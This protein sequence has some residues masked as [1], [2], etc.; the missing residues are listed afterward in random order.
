M[1]QQ[2]VKNFLDTKY[3]NTLC[4]LCD[5]R[6]IQLIKWYE[7]A[8]GDRVHVKCSSCIY[9]VHEQVEG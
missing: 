2:N 5:Q 8:H 3:P 1:E 6:S 9:D 7:N 4:P